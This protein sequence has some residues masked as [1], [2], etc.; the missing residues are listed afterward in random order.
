MRLL[1]LLLL[2]ACGGWQSQHHRG[3][4]LVG[5]IWGPDGPITERALVEQLRGAPYVLL[6]EKH[7]NPDHHRLQ[8]R[9]ILALTPKA[10]AFEMLDEDDDLSATTPRELAKAVDWANSG[11]PDFELYE[12]V[13]A[14]SY[15]IRAR[16]A[17]AHP[18]RS[19]LRRVY[20][21]GADL[22]LAELG[23]EGLAALREEIRESHCG[24]AKPSMVEPMVGVQR[25]KDAWMARALSAQQKPVV[26]IAG[27]GHTRRDR[28]VVAALPEAKVLSFVEVRPEKLRPQDYPRHA[29]YVWFTPRVD[30]ADPCVK[31]KAQLEEMS[32][33][34]R[35]RKGR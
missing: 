11:W 3:H 29:D 9:L 8:A 18:N 34:I 1:P 19:R 12:D 10:V 21:E 28:G 32:R 20:K 15:A 31:Y 16:I 17:Q 22:P 25:F 33:K 24:Y 30:I 26:L 23:P 27:K 35:A 13:F 6:G 7:D 5:Q 4:P 2:T 14:A